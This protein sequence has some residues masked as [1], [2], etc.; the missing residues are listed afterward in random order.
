MILF[1]EPQYQA[2]FKNPQS[3]NIIFDVFSITKLNPKL[4][5]KS[6][7]QKFFSKKE[8][9]KVHNTKQYF[10]FKRIIVFGFFS[11]SFLFYF[12]IVI[13]NSQV[14]SVAPKVQN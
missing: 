4:S 7:M 5:D 13:Y 14:I 10:F 8:K 1:H 2:H 11:F 6:M 12:I 3:H 9:K